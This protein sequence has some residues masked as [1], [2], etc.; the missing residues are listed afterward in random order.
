M[1][2]GKV[3]EFV[4]DKFGDAKG[5]VMDLFLPHVSRWDETSPLSGHADSKFC[6]IP[7]ENKSRCRMS[8]NGWYMQYEID[9]VQ[10]L[11]AQ[12]A[13]RVCSLKTVAS[14]N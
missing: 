2:G 13:Q 5:H 3:G 7:L 10:L 6:K 9:E 4:G 11:C 1:K 8:A 14:G 12:T